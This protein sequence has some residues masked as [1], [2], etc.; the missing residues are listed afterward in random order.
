[1]DILQGFIQFVTSNTGQTIAWVCTVFG[2][3]LAIVPNIRKKAKRLFPSKISPIGEQKPEESKNVKKEDQLESNDNANADSLSIPVNKKE[4]LIFHNRLIE[5]AKREWINLSLFERIGFIIGILGLV[6]GVLGIVISLL[7][8]SIDRLSPP[9][10]GNTA[11]N[12]P[13]VLSVS[14]DGYREILEDKSGGKVL[15]YFYDDFDGNSMMEMFA[16]IIDENSEDHE[17]GT[18]WYISSDKVV[19]LIDEE[20][21]DPYLYSIK[22]NKKVFLAVTTSLGNT[23]GSQFLYLWT[24]SN[25]IPQEY[26]LSPAGQKKVLY[27]NTNK[28]NELEIHVD[29]YDEFH[30]YVTYYLYYN[31]EDFHEYGGIQIT[32][33]DLCKVP[34]IDDVSDQITSMINDGVTILDIFYRENGII[35]INY[36]KDNMFYDY[37]R[38]RVLEDGKIEYPDHGDDRGYISSAYYDRI[39]T[40]PE[41]FPY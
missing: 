29:Y 11:V 2:F 14:I 15:E 7:L 28:Y 32:L 12:K 33:E 37:L 8:W 19:E 4:S 20:I 27:L 30:E 23:V 31:G 40:Y 18:F 3:I 10:E 13:Q 38:I 17:Y 34:G 22:L 35:D 21:V 1:M 24:V 26:S 36:V 9:D 5:Q 16:V 39:A 25:G 41:S 6:I